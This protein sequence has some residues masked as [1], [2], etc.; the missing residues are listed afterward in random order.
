MYSKI[1]QH[2]ITDYRLQ[3]TGTPVLF[4]HVLVRSQTVTTVHMLPAHDIHTY[5]CTRSK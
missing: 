4:V 1:V 2:A 3:I 5:R